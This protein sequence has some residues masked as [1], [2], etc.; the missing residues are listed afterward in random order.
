MR[1]LSKWLRANKISL[2]SSKTELLIFRH[3]S[4]QINYELKLRI[5]G[6]RL[7]PSDFVKY[8]GIIIDSHLK[9]NYHT[10]FIAPKLTRALGMLTKIRYFVDAN[11]LRSIYFGIFSSIMLYGVQIWG[12]LSNKY[13]NRITRLQDNAIRIIIF[14]KFHDSRGQ[15]YK[16]KNIL[17]FSDN[18]HLLNF[19]FAFDNYK[20]YLPS[21][22]DNYFTYSNEQHNYPTRAANRN[23]ILLPKKFTNVYGIKSITYQS[24]QSWNTIL[25]EYLDNDLY[26][27]SKFFCKKFIYKHIL[28]S[29]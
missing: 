26:N 27:K 1:F 14:S 18:V 15:L 19:L 3:P 4:K 16:N 20:G 8:L 25:K 6:R 13:V 5:N 23:L 10:D 17:K 28:N 7:Y 11:T 21:I 12:Q 24:A 22:F 29:Y 2:N 9:W